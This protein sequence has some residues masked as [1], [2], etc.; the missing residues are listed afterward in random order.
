MQVQELDFIGWSQ[1]DLFMRLKQIFPRCAEQ[2]LDP[3]K[4]CILNYVKRVRRTPDHFELTVTQKP[5]FWKGFPDVPECARGSFTS[6]VS[7][8]RWPGFSSFKRLLQSWTHPQRDTQWL[9]SAVGLRSHGH[10]LH[11]LPGPVPGG[12][13]SV[14]LHKLS[15]TAETSDGERGGEPAAQWADRRDSQAAGS[16]SEGGS[17]TN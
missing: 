8:Q 14:Y 13:G 5:L 9:L 2:I 11:R 7:E 15:R 4:K 1:L 17:L 16:A 10:G 12:L 3:T 6:P